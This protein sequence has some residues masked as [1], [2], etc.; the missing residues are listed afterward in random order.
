MSSSAN[1]HALGRQR[2]HRESIDTLRTRSG[3]IVSGIVRFRSPREAT[4]SVLMSLVY[5]L[6]TQETILGLQPVALQP[7]GVTSVDIPFGLM[8]KNAAFSVKDRDHRGVPNQEVSLTLCPELYARPDAPL[9]GRIGSRTTRDDGLAVT[10]LLVV[11][12]HCRLVGEFANQKQEA[13]L[14]AL[15]ALHGDP[16]VVFRFV[17]NVAEPVRV[18]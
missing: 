12:V 11:P 16:A 10:P 13:D 15:R 18:F 4:H 5:C 8:I 14:G 1:G 9:A 17:A 6:G 7:Y 3:E 2:L